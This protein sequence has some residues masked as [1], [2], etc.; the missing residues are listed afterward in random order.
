MVPASYAAAAEEHG[1]TIRLSS[2]VTAARPS[3]EE[4]VGW[5]LELNGG[6]QGLRVRTKT[7]INAAGCFGDRVELMMRHPGSPS[8]FTSLPRKGEYI[9]FEPPP[10]DRG[11]LRAPIQPVP[12]DR[13]KG[14]YLFRS[15]HGLIACG[16][17]AV[18]VDVFEDVSVS[19]K[20]AAELKAHALRVMPSLS[21]GRVVGRYAGLRPATDKR[22][23]Q[24]KIR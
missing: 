24:V 16:P 2:E 19:D 22:D 6:A 10:S 7:V 14:I 12:N 1:G 4:G 11:T 8:S 20:V 9:V 23:Y 15:S 18:D 5:E 17:T 3:S 13:T 21:E